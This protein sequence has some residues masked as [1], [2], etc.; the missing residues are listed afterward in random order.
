M[1]VIK[2]CWTP[3]RNDLWIKH[4]VDGSEIRRSPV[5]VGS[6]S[7]YVQGCLYARWYRI[8]SINSTTWTKR[9]E[10][11]TFSFE[12]L[13]PLCKNIY[14]WTDLVEAAREISILPI[15]ISVNDWLVVQVA[16]W[17]G[18]LKVRGWY[19]SQLL[20]QGTIPLGSSATYGGCEPRL[21]PWLIFKRY[22]SRTI[23]LDLVTLVPD[24]VVTLL[25]IPGKNDGTVGWIFVFGVV[26]CKGKTK[27]CSTG[28]RSDI[29]D[30]NE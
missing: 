1:K 13:R 28:F 20:N 10:A 9:W 22:L 26:V 3:T 27:T 21:G 17:N 8:S 14:I 19:F 23:F 2:I 12:D 29:V 30:Q 11:P 15:G 6:L 4:I 16:Y 7:H 25:G 5:E 24:W 18:L